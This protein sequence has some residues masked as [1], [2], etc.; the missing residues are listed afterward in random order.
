MST[1]EF[2]FESLEKRGPMVAVA[3]A[4]ALVL[5]LTLGRLEAL[6][7]GALL[8]F[9]GSAEIVIRLLGIRTSD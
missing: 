9:L 4:V 5:G 7:A 2:V 6:L 3:G 8:I 1:L